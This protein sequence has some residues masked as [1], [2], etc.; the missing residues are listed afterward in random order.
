MRSPR[1][2]SLID[3]C[4]FMKTVLIRLLPAVAVALSLI[5]PIAATAQT[6]PTRVHDMARHPVDPT[7]PAATHLST[8]S[9]SIDALFNA[10]APPMGHA[11][12][13]AETIPTASSLVPAPL[14]PKDLLKDPNTAWQRFLTQA[15][16]QPKPI[17][18]LAFF[19]IPQLESGLKM[20]LM[21]F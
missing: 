20:N 12:Q 11:T 15:P 9:R 8:A 4:N 19:E 10:E 5:A 6:A 16:A 14:S 18:P 7:Q 13:V 21:N 3:E 17:H 2:A 1:I